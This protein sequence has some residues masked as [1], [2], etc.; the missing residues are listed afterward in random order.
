MFP[1]RRPNFA[2]F[3]HSYKGMSRPMLV[4]IFLNKNKFFL[5][6]FNLVGL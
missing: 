1:A 2:E 3:G 5:S 6:K 4:Y